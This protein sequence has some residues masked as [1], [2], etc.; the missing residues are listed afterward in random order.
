MMNYAENQ[1]NPTNRLM[2]IVSRFP[3]PGPRLSLCI[4][5]RLHALRVSRTVHSNEQRVGSGEITVEK[6]ASSIGD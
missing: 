5:V 3:A 6:K 4:C 1:N 2:M